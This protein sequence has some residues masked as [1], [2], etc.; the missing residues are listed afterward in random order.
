MQ[1]IYSFDQQQVQQVHALYQQAW[2]AK[3]RSL[4]QTERCI[5]G[6]QVCVGIVDE[7]NQL[8]GFARV[9]TDFIFKAIIFDVIVKPDL[10]GTG[11]GRVLIN[12]IQQHPELKQV[13]HFE[14][15][16]LPE[17]QGYYEQFGF[18]SEVGGIKLMRQ[19]ND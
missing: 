2:W 13:K 19:V 1:T 8:L 12:S 6:S 18:S 9:L 4:S 16:C 5:N 15:Y 10:R 17:M 14:L 3:Q 7:K 11:L